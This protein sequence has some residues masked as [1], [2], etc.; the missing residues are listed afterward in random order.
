MLASRATAIKETARVQALVEKVMVHG[1]P[2]DLLGGLIFLDQSTR[3]ENK[4][5]QMNA[6]SDPMLMPQAGTEQA[7]TQLYRNFQGGLPGEPA[8]RL[9]GGQQAPAIASSADE[10]I[11]ELP[12][13]PAQ[14]E[15]PPA[16][17][18][19]TSNLGDKKRKKND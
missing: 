3:A 19:L 14:P 18:R 13:K 2:P 1:V 12:A 4:A 5:F 6:M 11:I 10:E 9:P 16:S 17:P 7:A 8:P 15:Q